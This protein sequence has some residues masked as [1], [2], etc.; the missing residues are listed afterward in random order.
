MVPVQDDTAVDDLTTVAVT[1]ET[2][3][4]DEEVAVNG[5]GETDEGG[6]H[7]LVGPYRINE[8]A[9]PVEPGLR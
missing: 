6:H 2:E 4:I 9:A 7:L 1:L 3:V 8:V 5:P